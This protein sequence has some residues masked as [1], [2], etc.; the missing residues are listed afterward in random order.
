[1]NLVAKE[2]VAARDDEQGVLVLSELT[3]AAQELKDA[4]IISPYDVEGFARAIRLA[5][6][7]PPEEQASRM[8]SLRRIVAGRDVFAWASDILGNLESVATRHLAYRRL[9]GRGVHS[10]RAGVPKDRAAEDG[11][12]R[13][14]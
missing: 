14:S 3:G 10:G 7:M 13:E 6:A 12:T 5:I 8:A 11:S 1:M 9:H 2:F 4:L